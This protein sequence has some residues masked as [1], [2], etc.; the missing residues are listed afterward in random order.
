MT[1]KLLLSAVAAATLVAAPAFA[2]DGAT[3]YIG[4]AYG[5][6]EVDTPLGDADAD[7]WGV[8]GAVAADISEN[9]G[10]QLDGA[11]LSMDD[12]DADALSG[13]VHLFHRN[14]QWALGGFAG[15][16]DNDSDTAWQIGAE[17]AYYLDQVT[18][19]GSIAYG[20]TDD[21]DVD[22]WGGG[23]EARFFATDNFRLDARGG[24]FN[25]DAGFGGDVD[26][27]TLGVGG[28]Y[29]FSAAPVSLYTTYDTVQFDDV[30]VDVNTWMVGVRWNFGGSLKDRD[31]NGAS[32]NGGLGGVLRSGF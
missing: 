30:D 4:A 5:N 18:F 6:V 26:G 2:Q 27:Y 17:G 16:T 25:A 11:Y 32:F 8:E 29:Q 9:F 22:V 15:V 20:T 10:I 23:V 19:A 1:K 13:T 21:T 12:I 3:G 7:A 14:D 28:E 31:R 24:L